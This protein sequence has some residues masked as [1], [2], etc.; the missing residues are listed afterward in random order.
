MYRGG[1]RGTPTNY[2]PIALISHLIKVFEKVLRGKI[3]TY[4]EEHGLFNPSKNGI[5][6]G[7]SCLS[8]VLSHYD[9]ILSLPEP[10]GNVDVFCI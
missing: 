3:V 7:R 4:M 1:C 9:Q 2:R 6:F 8:Q 5:R 10:G